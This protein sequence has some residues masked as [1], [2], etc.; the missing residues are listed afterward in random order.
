VWRTTGRESA[1]AAPA[2]VGRWPGDG[3]QGEP[4]AEA[5]T[6]HS[7]QHLSVFHQVTVAAPDIITADVLATAILAG[8]RP[9]L[10]LALRRWDIQVLACTADGEFL[11]TN[12]FR[13]TD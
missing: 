5:L 8:G 10:D 3:R 13:A 12:A 11:A 4:E 9:T 2:V 6:T 7:D 1:P